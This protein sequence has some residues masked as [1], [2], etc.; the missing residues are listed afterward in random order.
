MAEIVGSSERRL[1]TMLTNPENGIV[2]S[3]CRATSTTRLRRSISFARRP[4]AQKRIVG[5]A[6]WFMAR[7]RVSVLIHGQDGS[8]NR[9]GNRVFEV[10]DAPEPAPQVAL[11]VARAVQTAAQNLP[12][13]TRCLTQA[14]AASRMLARRDVSWVI[15]V[16]LGRDQAEGL[17]AHA[18]VTCGH[19]VVLGGPRVNRFARLIAYSPASE[20]DRK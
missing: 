12:W 11:D 1:P 18:W 7:A 6:A 19:D 8:L 15:H 17:I 5:E 13:N 4:W 2:R 10:I 9:H 14:L 20:A 16:G 3:I